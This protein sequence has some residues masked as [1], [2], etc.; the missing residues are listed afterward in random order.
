MRGEVSEELQESKRCGGEQKI[1]K[2]SLLVL[3][4]LGNQSK[5]TDLFF[6]FHF[7]LNCFFEPGEGTVE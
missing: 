1:G 3:L 4:F 2:G 6:R 5:R 7:L